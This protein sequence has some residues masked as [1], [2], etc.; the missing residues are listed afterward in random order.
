MHKNYFLS[1]SLEISLLQSNVMAEKGPCSKKEGRFELQFN[2]DGNA[3][4]LWAFSAAVHL[5]ARADS[6]EARV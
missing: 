6:T 1:K 2:L 4:V 5:A 3:S